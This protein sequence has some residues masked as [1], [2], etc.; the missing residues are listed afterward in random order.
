LVKAAFSLTQADSTP[1]SPSITIAV[2]IPSLPLFCRTRRL[3]HAFFPACAREDI[4]PIN[5]YEHHLGDYLKDAAH[6]SLL[7]DGALRRL[8]DVYYVRE[9]PL[10]LD[11]NECCKL[12]RCTSAA[13]RKAVIYVLG[14]VLT[15]AA[16]GYHYARADAAI[17]AYRA[18][19]PEREQKRANGAE[20]QSRFRAR[21]RQLFDELRKHHVT[22]AFDASMEELEALLLTVTSRAQSRG[23]HGNGHAPVTRDVT[24][25]DALRDAPVTRQATASHSHSPLPSN[26]SPILKTGGE[27]TRGATRPRPTRLPEDFALTPERRRYALENAVDP[28][29][30]FELFTSYWRGAGTAK[31]DWESTWQHWVL[32]DSRAV[33]AK[34][35]PRKTRF[36]E[37]TEHLR[38]GK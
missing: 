22:P 27:S 1:D 33:A 38:N 19:E 16:D 32:K 6:L 13:E 31:A 21:R 5:Y 7:E 24:Q 18:S 26:Q 20:R 15:K 23:S 25:S 8:L 2:F 17:A 4:F 37:L 28:Q 30:T 36:E 10:P 29:S 35:R 34:N 14:H 3:S 12:A 11:L 9:G